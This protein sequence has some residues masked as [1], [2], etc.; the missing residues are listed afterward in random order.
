MASDTEVENLKEQVDDRR[1]ELA[2]EQAEATERARARENDVA[3][4]QLQREKEV[5]EAAIEATKGMNVVEGD[6]APLS[7]PDPNVLLTGNEELDNQASDEN[8]E[9]MI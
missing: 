7:E 4:A 5:L 3:V 1:D 8:D 2:R 6:A 9:E